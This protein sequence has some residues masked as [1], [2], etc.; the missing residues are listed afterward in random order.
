MSRCYCRFYGRIAEGPNNFDEKTIDS[1]KANIE[2]LQKISGERIWM[3][4]KKILQGNFRFD[5]LAKM[6]ECGARRYIGNY[7]ESKPNGGEKSS[8]YVDRFAK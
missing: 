3:E 4:L 6:I 1:I 8:C 2:G 5:I 7:S